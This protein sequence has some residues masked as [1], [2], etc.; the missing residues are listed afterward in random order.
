M[1]SGDL[2]NA[3]WPS[4]GGRRMATPC[5]CRSAQV[6]YRVGPLVTHVAEPAASI[7]ISSDCTVS[8]GSGSIAPNTSPSMT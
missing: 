1:P 8:P 6:A 3:M 2:M 7:F 4:R 5:C